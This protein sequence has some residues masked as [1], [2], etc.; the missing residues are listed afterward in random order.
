MRTCPAQDAFHRH[1][2]LFV[3]GNYPVGASV[4]AQHATRADLFIDSVDAG[5]IGADRLFGAGVCAGATLVAQMDA[6]ISRSRKSAFNAQYG[7]AWTDSPMVFQGTGQAA[8][9][10]AGTFFV[11]RF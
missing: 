4:Y 11:Q 2:A 8:G 5:F 3:F 10:A 9:A 1:A 7:Q 6:V